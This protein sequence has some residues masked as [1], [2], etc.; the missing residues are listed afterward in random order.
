[1]CLGGAGGYVFTAP[2]ASYRAGSPRWDPEEE[3]HRAVMAISE[4]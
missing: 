4:L 1:M 2:S 3:D